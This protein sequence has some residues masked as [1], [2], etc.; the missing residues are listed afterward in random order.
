MCF[1]FFGLNEWGWFEYDTRPLSHPPF[2]LFS[3]T[4]ITY[5]IGEKYI[6]GGFM[7]YQ[8]P[9]FVGESVHVLELLI[10]GYVD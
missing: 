1:F 5:T 8:T 7:S 4:S 6:Y 10:L 9:Y 2:F 3:F